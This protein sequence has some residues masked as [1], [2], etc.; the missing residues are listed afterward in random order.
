MSH[1]PH[2]CSEMEGILWTLINI[3]RVGVKRTGPDS[4]QWCSAT[5]QGTTGTNWSTASSVRHHRGFHCRNSGFSSEASAHHHGRD[6]EYVPGAVGLQAGCKVAS[7]QPPQSSAQPWDLL[8]PLLRSSTTTCPH[9]GAEDDETGIFFT[10][11][12]V[13]SHPLLAKHGHLA[14]P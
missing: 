13:G 7:P 1:V 11:A 5:G 6:L 9:E 2:P 4:F 10:D 12:S 3:L 8:S 14:H